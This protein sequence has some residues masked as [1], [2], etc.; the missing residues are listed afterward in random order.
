MGI[1]PPF[2]KLANDVLR[3]AKADCQAPNACPC[4]AEL[5]DFPDLIATKIAE[6]RASESLAL[7]PDTLESRSYAF[8]DSNAFLLS[9]GRQQRNHYVFER[10]AGIRYG[11][12][13]LL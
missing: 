3:R 5:A 8:A 10:A 1:L 6:R 13:K 7:P 2:T 9:H 4:S 11:S 12:V